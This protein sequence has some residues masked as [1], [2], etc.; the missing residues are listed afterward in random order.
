MGLEAKENDSRKSA[1]VRDVGAEQQSK[2][3]GLKLTSYE[4]LFDLG[5]K[6]P[7]AFWERKPYPKLS[8]LLIS[9]LH[10]EALSTGGGFRTRSLLD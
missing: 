4:R 9:T 5:Q 1:K 8:L 10:G 6:A 3:T 7:W 2:L